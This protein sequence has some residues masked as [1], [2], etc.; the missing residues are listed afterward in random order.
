MPRDEIERVVDKLY[1]MN[2]MNTKSRPLMGDL[3]SYSFFL[4][5]R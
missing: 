5:Y 3:V 2:P 1:H 4:N